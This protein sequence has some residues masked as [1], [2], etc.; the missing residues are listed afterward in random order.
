MTDERSTIYQQTISESKKDP[1]FIVT[2]WIRNK[3]KVLDVGCA[4]GD[5]GVYLKNNRGCEMYGFEYNQGSIKIAEDTSAYI[6]IHQADLNSFSPELFNYQSSFDVIV[7]C[8]VLEHLLDP[9]ATIQKLK[10]FL[11][12]DGFILMSIPNLTHASIKILLL[13][14][15]IDYRKTGLLDETHL[16][17]FTWRSIYDLL[18]RAMLDVAAVDMTFCTA[19]TGNLRGYITN[20]NVLMYILQDDESYVVQYVLKVCK[21]PGKPSFKAFLSMIK[22][23][24]MDHAP[25]INRLRSKDMLRLKMLNP[26][27][28]RGNY[29]KLL[30]RILLKKIIYRI[31]PSSRRLKKINDLTIKADYLKKALR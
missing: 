24:F 31:S 25:L 29:I 9:L 21:A 7:L 3:A 13:A 17:F 27:T 14:N 1:R 2:K 12:E 26:Y 16:R 10:S 30:G 5:L 6:R 23:C 22:E 20:K 15:K 19:F 8:D 18:D 28:L 4:C 11:K